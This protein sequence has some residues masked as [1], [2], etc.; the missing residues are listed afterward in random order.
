M[1]ARRARKEPPPTSRT[2]KG[3]QGS[4]TSTRATWHPP[5]LSSA[6]C[7]P[8]SGVY[9]ATPVTSP[10]TDPDDQPTTCSVGRRLRAGDTESAS[11][12]RRDV[13]H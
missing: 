8:P 11:T 5:G 12:D 4:A 13:S 2:C 3:L 6:T 9:S 1:T 7:T 10:A